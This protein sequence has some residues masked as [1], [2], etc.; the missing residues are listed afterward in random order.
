MVVR[1]TKELHE[2]FD[3]VQIICTI[4]DSKGTSLI[5]RGVGNLYARTGSMQS[6]LDQ[7]QTG[8]DPE[9]AFEDDEDDED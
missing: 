1:A 9:C 5:A 3:T 7:I 4:H 2:H 6:V 8:E